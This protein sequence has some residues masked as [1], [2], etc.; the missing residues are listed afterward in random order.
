MWQRADQDSLQLN[1]GA[2]GRRM[3][4]AGKTPFDMRTVIAGAAILGFALGGFFDG[5]LLHQVLQWHHFLSLARGEQYTDIRMQIL[6]DGLFHVAVYVITALALWLLWR[7]GQSRPGDRI[8]L[9]WAAIGFGIW[10]LSDVVI[11]HWII[12]IHNIRVGVPNPFLWDVGL[13]IV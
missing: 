7:R 10:Q 13:L 2:E 3:T 8:L 6:A 4:N 12:G 5:I 11:F 1:T 9:A